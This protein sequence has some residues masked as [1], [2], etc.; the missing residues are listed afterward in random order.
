M[1]DH[2][3][4]NKL[5]TVLFAIYMIALFW[6]ILFKLNIHMN[7]QRS[8][9][10]IPFNQPLILNGRVDLGEVILN[11]LI[12]IPLGLY[13]G[14]LFKRW[15]IGKIIL[16]FFSISLIIEV[17]QFIFA[18]GASDITD[19]ITNTLGGIIGLTMYIGIEK[20]FKSSVKA[21]KFINIL[22]VAG[23]TVILLL[24][25]LLK[26]NHLWMFRM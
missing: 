1:K 4:A 12:F 18:I 13:A 10:L 14:V 7:F 6:I 17:L 2:T 5:T 22:A 23:T 25:F 24:L 3:S 26:V 8:L 9:N 15:N 16:L 21:Q 11:V 20:A 19:V